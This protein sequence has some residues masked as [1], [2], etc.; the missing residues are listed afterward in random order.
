MVSI[1]TAFDCNINSLD[2][3]ILSSLLYILVYYYY[4]RY[5]II[6]TTLLSLL[7]Y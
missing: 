1:A 4:Y 3:L 5:T 2:G 6:A 7:H